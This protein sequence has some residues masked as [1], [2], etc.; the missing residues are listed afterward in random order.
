[1]AT[2]F[3]RLEITDGTTTVT[4]ESSTGATLNYMLKYS[5]WS[6]NIARKR[7]VILSGQDH[8][9]E[10]EEQLELNIKGSSADDCYTKLET[11]IKLL[12]QANRW[13]LRERVNPV[14][15][16]YQPKGSNLSTY[17]QA[18][19]LRASPVDRSIDLP[20]QFEDVGNTF[21]I[22]GVTIKFIRRGLW[23]TLLDTDT[24]SGSASNSGNIISATSGQS[25]ALPA[26]TNLA[27][28]SFFSGSPKVGTATGYMLI[29]SDSDQIGKIDASGFTGTALTSVADS[30]NKADGNVVRFTPTVANQAVVSN[31]V[32]LPNTYRSKTLGFYATVRVNTVSIPFQLGVRASLGGF[33]VDTAYTPISAASLQPQVIYLGS[34]S[35]AEAE[36]AASRGFLSVQ[37]KY[38]GPTS[39]AGTPT[40]DIDTIIIVGLDDEYTYAIWLYYAPSGVSTY[41]DF[42]NAP[43]RLLNPQIFGGVAPP[44]SSSPSGVENDVVIYDG[45]AAIYTKGTNVSCCLLTV[46]D[47]YW[48]MVDNSN[49]LITLSPSYL[50]N[51]SYLIPK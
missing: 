22:L 9:M 11:L 21:W 24:F 49:N 18:L 40:L 35:C 27:F 48:R 30:T 44:I 20:K 51:N 47:Q 32:A 33:T 8:Y 50:R 37:L 36:T 38:I 46:V 14:T 23:I 29:T 28:G 19:I 15:I 1:M 4:I 17:C 13:F 6:P 5:G 10:V 26:P 43:T 45:N 34:V 25:P 3:S 39:I 31:G 2:S 16:R 12:D 42:R 41:M 7:D